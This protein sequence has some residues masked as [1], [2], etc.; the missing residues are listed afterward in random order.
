MDGRGLIHCIV[1]VLYTIEGRAVT[2]CPCL[3]ISHVSVC[4]ANS[5]PVTPAILQKGYREIPVTPSHVWWHLAPATG[6][7]VSI[8]PCALS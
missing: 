7:S 4:A 6:L 3:Y 5:L 1:V 2:T 8:E